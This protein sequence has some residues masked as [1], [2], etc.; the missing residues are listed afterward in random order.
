[1]VRV[2]AIVR[3]SALCALLLLLGCGDGDSARFQVSAPLEMSGGLGISGNLAA[4]GG[5][6]NSVLV[7]TFANLRTEVDP[8]EE[9]PI[10]VAIVEEDNKF[11]FSSQ[12]G[13]TLTVVFL[14]DDA[15]DGVIDPGDPVAVLLDPDQQL[16]DLRE[17]DQVNLVDVQLDFTTRHAV[18][19]SIEVVRS[20]PPAAPR[21][22]TPTIPAS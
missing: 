20:T 19:A 21:T 11:V 1:M 15:S 14:A 18:A 7:F 17:G 13:D 16:R 3:R 8:A 12:T 22:V 6:A 10:C 5:A 2:A 9:E 4:N